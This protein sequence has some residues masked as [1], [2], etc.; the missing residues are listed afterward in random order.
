M[1]LTV[2][3][4]LAV[5]AIFYFYRRYKKLGYLL[6]KPFTPP[7]IKLSL[8]A[9]L[10]A[11]QRL[12][13]DKIAPSIH[14]GQKYY[15][16]ALRL[17][18]GQEIP[19]VYI[20]DASEHANRKCELPLDFYPDPIPIEKVVDIT[21]SPYRLPI[22]LGQ[23]LYKQGESTVG[24]FSFTVEFSDGTQLSYAMGELVDFLDTPNGLKASEIVRV[25]PHKAVAKDQWKAKNYR[26]CLYRD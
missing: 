19:C 2:V 17:A 20:I 15:P 6:W 11:E 1:I 13:L 22:Y 10:S 12:L 4:L 8:I 21:E 18:D 3:G 9:P 26:W 16:C 14:Y 24:A 25:I 5:L 7:S 23:E